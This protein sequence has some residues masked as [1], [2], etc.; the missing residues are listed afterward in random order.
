MFKAPHYLQYVIVALILLL[1]FWLTAFLS[2][3]RPLGEAPD[4]RAHL[5]YIKFIAEE[6]RLPRSMSERQ[7]VGYKSAAP[8]LYHSLVA[9]LSHFPQ[10]DPPQ[11]LKP[12]YAD[13]RRLLVF[14]GLPEMVYLH[15]WDEAWPFTGLVYGWHRARVVSVLLGCGTL[16]FVF[17]TLRR[18]FS[19]WLSLLTTMLVGL[20]PQFVAMSSVLNDDNLLGFLCAIFLWCLWP[21]FDKSGSWQRYLA[22]GLLAGLALIAKYSSLFLP[23]SLIILHLVLKRWPSFRQILAFGG[24]YVV[25]ILGWFVFVAYHFNQID[26]LG[27]FRGLLAPFL[28]GGSDTTSHQIAGAL[29]IPALYASSVD[30]TGLNWLKWL[31][32]MAQT[33]WFPQTVVS[34]WLWL[35]LGLGLG[36]ALVGVSC[37]VFPKIGKLASIWGNQIAKKNKHKYAEGQRFFIFPFASLR[38]CVKKFDPLNRQIIIFC[39]LYILLFVPLPLLRFILTQNITE[40]AQGRHLLFPILLPLAWLLLSGLRYL[41]SIQLT[42]LVLGSI[43]AVLAV[44][45]FLAWPDLTLAHAPPLPVTTLPPTDPLALSLQYDFGEGIHLLGLSHPPN[46]KDD[47]LALTLVWYATAPSAQDFPF[48]VMV[49]DDDENLVGLWQGQPIN[50][51][52]PS[53]AWSEGDYVYDALHIPL[54]AGLSAGEYRVFIQALSDSE[55]TLPLAAF[56]L[57]E[58][59]AVLAPNTPTAIRLPRSDGLPDSTPYRYRNTLAYHLLSLGKEDDLVLRDELGKVY[60]PT[61]ILL[62]GEQAIALFTVNWDWPSGDYTLI[63]RNQVGVETALDMVP[64]FNNKRLTSVPPLSRP[65]EANFNNQFVLRGYDLPQNQVEAGGSFPVTLAWQALKITNSNYKVF[66][67]LLNNEQVQYG[68]QDHLPQG[69]YSTILWQPGEVV[70]DSYEVPVSGQAPDGIYW[71]DV[72]LYPADDPTAPALPLLKDG[73]PAEIGSVLLGPIKVGGQPAVSKPENSPKTKSQAQ[74]GQSIR[75]DGYTLALGDEDMLKLDLYW[76]ALARVE[77]DYTVF[78]HILDESGEVV[79]QGDGPPVGGQYPTS[80]WAEG[81]SI[82]DTRQILLSDLVSGQYTLRLGWYEAQSGQR[83][84]VSE[85]GVGFV[86]LVQFELD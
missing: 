13:P 23:L 3:Q 63:S 17:L 30:V 16:L 60:P 61:T 45:L 49:L 36:L 66:N 15:T 71:L 86:D 42:A 2:I 73:Q 26:R 68:G 80:L 57:P 85:A 77:L 70:V 22:L 41:F 43:S 48:K 76:S 59:T 51:R 81:E 84:P 74:F 27:W 50:G 7:A 34:W 46:L 28:V 21:L 44:S 54:L 83:L 1:F 25:G 4:E 56:N 12:I 67:H 14:D 31:K 6:G 82:F 20:I 40:T 75:L 18:K 39:L 62:D 33:F 64:I 55:T 72:G 52:Y 24:A 9:A 78:I 47:R 69:W 19:W 5:A 10:D 38:L 79:V 32:T 11:S 53:R 29:G 65:L 35:P 58:A 37:I 8:P